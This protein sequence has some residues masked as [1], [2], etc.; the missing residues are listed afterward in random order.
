MTIHDTYRNGSLYVD[1]NNMVD[2]LEDRGLL[3]DRVGEILEQFQESVA[4]FEFDD[5]WPHG[6]R[7]VD[8][9][10]LP[11]VQI[12][13]FGGYPGDAIDDA[14][15]QAALEWAEGREYIVAYSS[16]FGGCQH[17]QLLFDPTNSSLSDAEEAVELAEEFAEYPVL[18]EDLYSEM[19][20][21]R[22]DEMV[23]EM[24]V[25][26]EN[27]RDIVF[28]EDQ[29]VFIYEATQNFYGYWD[30]GYFAE[31]EWEKIVAEALDTKG[32]SVQLH[33]ETKLW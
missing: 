23:D 14:N 25:D 32:V 27:E 30:E 18:D 12:G 10:Q 29:R 2:F 16:W 1:A 26:T 4:D 22:W 17:V 11:L 28:T 20:T 21:Q 15:A 3:T 19:S 33:Q 13:W 8:E 6:M 5:E 31:E 24:T 9:K 7:Y